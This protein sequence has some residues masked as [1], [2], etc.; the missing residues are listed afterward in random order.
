MSI[1]TPRRL[2]GLLAAG[3]V[4]SSLSLLASGVPALTPVSAAPV[5]QQNTQPPTISVT[6]EG[7]VRADPDMATISVGVTAVAPTSQAAMD[8]VNR[9]L[10]GVVS[11]ARALGVDNRDLQTSGLSLQ[12]IY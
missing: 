9:K 7:E 3:A 1:P 4:I 10:A 2:V 5:D 12:P 6:G 8:E 11:G